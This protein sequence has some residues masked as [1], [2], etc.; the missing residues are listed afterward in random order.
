MIR[1]NGAFIPDL[2][3]ATANLR[4]LTKN[5]SIFEWTEAHQAEFENLKKAFSTDVLLRHYDT[6][7]NTFIFVDAHFTGL[8]AILAQGQSPD[9]SKAVALASRT[10]TNAE[11]N[12]S[13][14]D[15]EATA[16]D[17]GLRRFRHILVGGP[18]VVVVTDQ[19][20]LESLWKSK[21]KPSARIE[22]ILL[23]HQ[24]IN[25]R[26]MWKKGKENPA[27]FI[28]RH[29]IPLQKLPRRIAEEASEHQKLLFLLHNPFLASTAITRERLR[30]AQLNDSTL[31]RLR[32][33]IA[34]NQAPTNDPTLRGYHKLFSELSVINDVIHRGDQML[35]PESLREEAISLAH[36]GSHPGQDAVKRRLRAHF[37]F[38]GMDSTIQRQM[39]KCHE[40]QVRTAS[41]FKAPLT[42]TPIPEK[43]WQAISIDLFGPLPDRRHIL[44]ARCNLSRFPDAKIVRSSGAK[45]ILPA[46]G[47]IYKNF[48]YPE[49]HKCDNGPPFNGQEFLDWSRKRGIKVKNPIHTIPKETRPNAL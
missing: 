19:Q 29:A 46:L 26:V 30:A 33:F 32:H 12:Y 4:N 22:R 10:T 37:W 23:R 45:H 11:K 34:L 8:C 44:V 40:C 25:H 48:G 31:S 14:L 38:P 3:A 5:N 36:E 20:P 21:R 13:Q 1:S 27:D 41:P 6:K 18:Q 7:E 47:E 2:A 49:H 39:E 16:I 24:D 9:E 43:P 42:P 35:L 28:S 17:F 15:L